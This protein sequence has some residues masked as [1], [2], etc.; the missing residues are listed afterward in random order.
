M[1]DA[2]FGESRLA[3]IYD[4]VDADRSDLE[5]YADLVDELDAHSVLD[6]GCGTGTFACL[7]AQRGKAVTG[8]DP[9]VA[10]LEVARRK[11]G[12]GRVRWLVGDATTLPPL[13]VD[14]VT[15]T[16]NVAQVFLTDDDWAS[17]LQAVRS[18]LRSGGSLVFEVR[19]PARE[20][21]REWNREQSYQRIE[22]TDGGSV[23]TW[24]DLTDVSVPFVSF[25]STFVFETDGAVLT[26]DSTLRFRSHAELSQSLRAAG[27]VVHEVRDAPDRPG[28]ELV[29]IAG[30]LDKGR[31]TDD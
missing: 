7:L 6:I 1:V 17:T 23:E 28:R 31:A 4:A 29:F 16:A 14:L 24:I 13:A 8:V 12:A 3:D 18:A 10:S 26:S 5:V 30:R 11:P 27:F 9:A 25:R 15:M 22:L 2:I 20:A 21:W 19:E